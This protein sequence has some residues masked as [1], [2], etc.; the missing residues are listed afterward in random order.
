[1]EMKY[2]KEQAVCLNRSTGTRIRNYKYWRFFKTQG[3]LPNNKRLKTDTLHPLPDS[4]EE[5][6]PWGDPR[7][8]G[9]K[10]LLLCLFFVPVTMIH[11]PS[12]QQRSI[13]NSTE[14]KHNNVFDCGLYCVFY[15]HFVLNNY[16][17]SFWCIFGQT[18]FL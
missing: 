18:V 10:C 17:F 6:R 8:R 1:M 5:F 9:M 11:S 14:K 16:P 13:Y 12:W 7:N 2:N 3:P 15:Q 4:K